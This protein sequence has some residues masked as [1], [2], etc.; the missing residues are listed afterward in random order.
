LSKRS[1]LSYNTGV[2]WFTKPSSYLSNTHF[3]VVYRQ[4]ILRKWLFYELIPEVNW[5]KEDELSH[6]KQIY[7]FTLRLEVLFENI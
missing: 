7:K 6:T 4:N 1:A 2:T 5:E 3:S